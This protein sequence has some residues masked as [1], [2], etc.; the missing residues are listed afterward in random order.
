MTAD[1][2]LPREIQLLVIHLD[3]L[4]LV[5]REVLIETN[6]CLGQQKLAYSDQ[7]KKLRDISNQAIRNAIQ[8][9]RDNLQQKLLTYKSER[10]AKL[11]D[12]KDV[13][14]QQLSYHKKS[15]LEAQNALAT[16]QHQLVEQQAKY[17]F[18]TE[19][20][21]LLATERAQEQHKK[22]M[23]EHQVECRN[24]ESS[25]KEE[26]NRLINNLEAQ[27]KVSNSVFRCCL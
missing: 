6:S 25:M 12:E 1:D 8:L 15:S 14:H 3:K 5:I 2:Q 9:E 24:R 27:H 23:Y 13:L 17:H 19:E 26:Y 21:V 16:L 20:K 10:E 18:L 7:L 11:I 22:D 4:R